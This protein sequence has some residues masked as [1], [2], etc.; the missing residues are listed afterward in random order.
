M[1]VSGQT[2][3]R[4]VDGHRIAISNPDKVLFPAIGVTKGELVDH[5]DTF[6]E[7]MLRH[8][9]GRP[10]TLIR[11]PEGVEAEGWFQKHAPAHLPAWIAR[12]TLDSGEGRGVEHVVANERATLVYLANLAAIELHVGPAG[13]H[14][15]DRPEELVID[16]DPPKGADV[17][18]VRR[19]TRRCRE[20]L[21]EL[22]VAPR[23][24]SSGSSGFHVHVPLDGGG[25]QELA[26]DIAR[27]VAT[28]LAGRFPRELTVEHRIQRRRGRVFV[29]WLR[30]S[31]RQTFIAPYSVRARPAAP[32]AAPM[33]WS[34]LARTEPQRWSIRS[35]RR[36]L[37][38]RDDPWSQ[39]PSRTDLP[40]LAAN[41]SAALQEIA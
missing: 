41:L 17:A 27:G 28:V 26:R 3:Q 10:L 34:E 6:G 21:V 15:P 8:V 23:L 39:P 19:A 29:D 30:N 35:I 20:L 32:V 7:L 12:A 11:H 5:Y 36:R 9:R 1:V 16:L 24:K 33:D 14:A 25:S 4:E 22:G 2:T 31:P 38:Q 13:A 37:A 18:M 40:R